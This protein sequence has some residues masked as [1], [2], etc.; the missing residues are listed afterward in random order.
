MIWDFA[1]VL[2]LLVLISGIIWAI[3]S[4]FFAKRRRGR[5]GEPPE[6]PPEE[7]LAEHYR[8]PV[9]VDYARS[10]F[11]IFLIVLLLRLMLMLLR[12]PPCPGPHSVPRR[13]DLRRW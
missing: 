9:I 1:A 7:Q 2:S 8:V 10:F 5:R 11:P 4:L 3:D 12:P 6:N 13:R